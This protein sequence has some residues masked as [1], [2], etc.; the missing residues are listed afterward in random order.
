MNE[1][2]AKLAVKARAY[3]DYGSFGMPPS[4]YFSERDLEKFAE[5]IV[6]ECVK[7]C[8]SVSELEHKGN[9]ISE[10]SKRMRKHFGVEV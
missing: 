8:W 9:V 3:W 6:E 5:F 1:R 7:Q 2:I 4:V 10:C